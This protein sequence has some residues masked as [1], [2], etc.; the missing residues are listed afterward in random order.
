MTFYSQYVKSIYT[1]TDRGC[2]VEW[3]DFELDFLSVCT[4]IEN[5]ECWSE[6][7]ERLESLFQTIHFPRLKTLCININLLPKDNTFSYPIFQHVTHLDIGSPFGHELPCWKGLQ[8]LQNVTHMRVQTLGVDDSY[9]GA[10]DEVIEIAS[11]AKRYFPPG[12]QYFVILMDVDFL[13][14]AIIIEDSERWERFEDIR[15]GRFDN[16]I[17]LGCYDASGGDMAHEIEEDDQEK[18]NRYEELVAI[19]PRPT[20]PRFGLAER[21]TWEEVARIA[22]KRTRK[23]S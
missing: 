9:E 19:L 20:E 6:T 13:W 1:N 16:R 5:L 14:E 3:S 21:F 10:M 12:L 11:E 8:S 23:T 7:S 18:I 2:S 22:T 4:N 17:L 15:L